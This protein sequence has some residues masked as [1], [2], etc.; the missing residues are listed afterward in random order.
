MALVLKRVT[1]PYECYRCRITGEILDYGAWYYEDDVDGY[2]VSFE[3][4]YDTK[5]AEKEREVQ[6]QI[7]QQMS[8]E[9]YKQQ[10]KQQEEAFLART[11]FERPLQADN[12]YVYQGPTPRNKGGK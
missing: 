2:I 4:Y 8:I 3:Y 6:W 11:A 1:N 5:Q 12:L 9:E 7:N 10:L